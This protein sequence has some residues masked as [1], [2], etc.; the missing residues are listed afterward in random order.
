M[1]VAVSTVNMTAR[2][3]E[4]GRTKINHSLVA[5]L[6]IIQGA[7]FNRWTNIRWGSTDLMLLE[8]D[9]ERDRVSD[10]TS[11]STVKKVCACANAV[12]FRSDALSSTAVVN[13]VRVRGASLFHTASRLAVISL[14]SSWNGA[15]SADDV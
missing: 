11:F 1:V 10:N 3:S 5:L 6:R 2:T 8:S 12:W 14:A 13:N 4:Q 15:F 9:S 7:G